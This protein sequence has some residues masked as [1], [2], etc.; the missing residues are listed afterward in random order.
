MAPAPETLTRVDRLIEPRTSYNV[1]RVQRDILG[2]TS[3]V[4]AIATAVVRERDADAF[5]GG[6]DYNFRWN[7]NLFQW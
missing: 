2:G 3:N 7:R 4:G 5:T 6:V 1:V